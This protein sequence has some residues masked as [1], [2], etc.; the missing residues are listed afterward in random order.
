MMRID[1]WFFLAALIS[2]LFLSFHSLTH[3]PI[4]YYDIY[5]VANTNGKSGSSP[6]KGLQVQHS[7]TQNEYHDSWLGKYDSLK[8]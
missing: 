6:G 4:V 8:D 2:F 3:P 5:C 7:V 1:S